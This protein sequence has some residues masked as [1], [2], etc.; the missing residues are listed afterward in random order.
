MKGRKERNDRSH[1]ITSR[2]FHIL[3]S[4]YKYTLTAVNLAIMCICQH[5]Q[6]YE[7]STEMIGE[8][9]V[10]ANKNV[11]NRTTYHLILQS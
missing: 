4:V 5:L 7:E 11:P 6:M 1:V 10:S 3:T 9:A 8:A 2:G